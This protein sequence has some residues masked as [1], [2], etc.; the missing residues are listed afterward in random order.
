MDARINSFVKSPRW[1]TKSVPNGVK[2]D[3]YV[4]VSASSMMDK[5]QNKGKQPAKK[6]SY[7]INKTILWTISETLAHITD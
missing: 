6:N 5:A 7:Q 1:C 2:A 3:M 4:P